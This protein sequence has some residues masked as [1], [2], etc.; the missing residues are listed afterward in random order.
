MLLAHAA[1]PDTSWVIA[2]LSHQCGGCESKD[3]ATSSATAT[4]LHL[5]RCQALGMG[6]RTLQQSDAL[7]IEAEACNISTFVSV[8]ST[9]GPASQI[10]TPTDRHMSASVQNR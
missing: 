1:H 3:K 6:W 9:N 2:V 8:K 4:G 10:R 5:Y 7:V